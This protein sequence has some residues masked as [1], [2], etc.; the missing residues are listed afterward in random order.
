MAADALPEDFRFIVKIDK[1]FGKPRVFQSAEKYLDQRC[2]V[3]G[4]NR[5]GFYQ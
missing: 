4:E 2:A 5:L 1:A 3:K